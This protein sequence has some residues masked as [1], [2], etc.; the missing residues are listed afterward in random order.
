MQ[1]GNK[2]FRGSIIPLMFIFLQFSEVTGD[3]FIHFMMEDI[4]NMFS[5]EPLLVIGL[6]GAAT[7]GAFILED[8]GGNGCFMG[9]GYLRSCSEVCD[10]AFD[11]PL[12]GAS[13]ITWGIG[14]LSSSRDVEET[15]Q[16]LTE[17]LLLSFGIT[18]AMKFA[19]GRTRPDGSNTRSFP[20]GHSSG[21]ACA[22]V[23]LWDRY[24][25]GAGIP[26]A[27][28]AAFTA[29]S[30]VTL[31]KHYP[32]DVIA[33]A[34]IGIA[35]GLAVAEAHEESRASGQQIQ[36]ALGITWSSAGGFGVYF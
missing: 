2:L 21:T 30:R 24:G 12:L 27:A 28:V 23:I 20:S 19:T 29:L 18:G 3:D 15:G 34:A 32:S 8:H 13:S 4:H 5:S 1:K 22:A 7:A 16:M 26:A 17:G 6:G 25:A 9:D 33:G 35:M 31:E 11:L 10:K 14:A 36:P